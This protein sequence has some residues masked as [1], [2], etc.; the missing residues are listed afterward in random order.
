MKTAAVAIKRD[1]Q[2]GFTQIE[3]MVVVLI[4]GVFSALIVPDVLDR[5]DDARV[6]AGKT[7]IAN[8]MHAL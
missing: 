3:L 6:T 5:V 8:L 7:D 4:I 1:I 2:P